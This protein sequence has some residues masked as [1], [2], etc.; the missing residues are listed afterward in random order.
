MPSVRM[1]VQL[2]ERDT[3]EV[4]CL[5]DVLLGLA[6]HQRGDWGECT[7]EE[8]LANDKALDRPL[9]IRSR[10]KDRRGHIFHII[11][12]ADRTMTN[13]LAVQLQK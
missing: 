3:S 7:A 2:I 4:I 1:G 11:T 9:E 10:H 8:R 12:A 13:V 6:R 5:S